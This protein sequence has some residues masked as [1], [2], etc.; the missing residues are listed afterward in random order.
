MSPDCFIHTDHRHLPMQQQTYSVLKS[1]GLSPRFVECPIEALPYI[2]ERRAKTDL[3]I[4]CEY[5]V[6]SIRG[7]QKAIETMKNDVTINMWTEVQ[8][9]V[10]MR[11]GG[12][13]TNK[14]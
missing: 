10:I 3:Y 14:L 11:K 2:C 5:N 9:C 12:I 1:F 8:G 6:G 13:S 7:L 4:L